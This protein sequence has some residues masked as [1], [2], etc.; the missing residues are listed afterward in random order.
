MFKVTLTFTN[1]STSIKYIIDHMNELKGTSIFRSELRVMIRPNGHFQVNNAY[2]IYY[3]SDK[4][5]IH[6]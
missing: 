2:F 6:P 5:V 1:M 3:K 4:N